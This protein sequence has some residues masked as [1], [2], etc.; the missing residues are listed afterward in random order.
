MP[1]AVEEIIKSYCHDCDDYRTD[2]DLIAE[3]LGG[4]DIIRPF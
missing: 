4:F 2:S 1:S 3:E